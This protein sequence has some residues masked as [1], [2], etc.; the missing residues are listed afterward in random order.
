MKTKRFF[1]YFTL[2]LYVILIN[3][4]LCWRSGHFHMSAVGSSVNV[5]IILN[6][7]PSIVKHF[8]SYCQKRIFTITKTYAS[9]S[10]CLS[11][12]LHHSWM[13]SSHR[14]CVN[15]CIR[16]LIRDIFLKKLSLILG[17]VEASIPTAWPPRT[18]D[19]KLMDFFFRGI[20]LDTSSL[21]TRTQGAI[22][23]ISEEISV[24]TCSEI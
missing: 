17:S 13:I 5:R 11:Y 16:F 1:F 10:K 22:L 12:T 3:K 24:N 23:T 18:P 2:Y 19:I 15:Q 14:L 9:I 4:L 8:S 20:V 21:E 6:F 7:C